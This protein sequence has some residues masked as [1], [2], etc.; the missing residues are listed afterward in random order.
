MT[1]SKTY[2]Y[3]KHCHSS[4]NSIEIA[5]LESKHNRTRKRTQIGARHR[6]EALVP[7]ENSDHFG[8]PLGVIHRLF[9]D[10]D[11]GDLCSATLDHRE[12]SR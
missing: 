6:D 11:C 5:A 2:P 12:D 9:G 4:K 3:I 8:G 7:I 10:Y 1:S